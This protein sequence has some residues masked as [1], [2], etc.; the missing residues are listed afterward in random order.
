MIGKSKSYSLSTNEVLD[1]VN[2]P[3]TVVMFESIK[4]ME[5]LSDL[6]PPQSFSDNMIGR[7]LLNYLYEDNYGHW[8]GLCMKPGVGTKATI[9][10]FDPYGTFIDD[11]IKDFPERVKLE[12]NSD[13]PYLLK[14]LYQSGD[15]VY[16]NHVQ[17]Q[18]R[19]VG[20]NTCGRWA[21]LFL[22]YCGL[23]TVDEFAKIFEEVSKEFKVSK[24]NLVTGVTNDIVADSPIFDD[25]ER[26][27]RM[28]EEFL[29][30]YL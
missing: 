20:I 21:G 11:T 23:C 16:Y 9:E 22:R 25:V 17:L 2:S 10:Y 24:D 14:L 13:Y 26:E 8:V 19:K 5:S 3:C 28:Q 4:A 30:E 15:D 7:C 27:K 12:H 1:I 18:D 29:Y 6:F